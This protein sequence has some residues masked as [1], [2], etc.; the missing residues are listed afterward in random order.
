MSV[1]CSQ[2]ELIWYPGSGR[3]AAAFC[4][5]GSAHGFRAWEACHTRECGYF[6]VAGA[7]FLQHFHILLQQIHE[8]DSRHGPFDFQQDRKDCPVDLQHLLDDYEVRS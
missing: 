1:S 8:T 5:A 2:V 3:P 7:Y 4:A 6:L